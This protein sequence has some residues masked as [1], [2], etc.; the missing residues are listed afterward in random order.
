MSNNSDPGKA[1][2]QEHQSALF[3]SL[4]MQQFS[5]AMMLMGRTQ[6]PGA[7]KAPKDLEAARLFIDQLE[8]LESKT[9][10]NLSNDEAA[11]LKQ[12]LMNL[13][14]TFVEAVEEGDKAQPSQTHG[15]AKPAATP[16]PSG[17][18]TPGASSE[19]SHKKFSKKY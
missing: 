15:D 1:Q 18:S 17:E 19:E 13:R 8:M 16:A 12:S 11:L 10:G 4:V 9:R 5:M 14:M 3:S 2:S 7:E 6:M